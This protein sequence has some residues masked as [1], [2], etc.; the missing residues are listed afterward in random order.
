MADLRKRKKSLTFLIYIYY[1]NCSDTIEMVTFLIK[2]NFK[3]DKTFSWPPIALL[4]TLSNFDLSN[5]N[6]WS[7]SCLLPSSK[8]TS[9]SKDKQMLELKESLLTHS[10]D[11]VEM[12]RLNYWTQGM[13][14]HT[15]TPVPSTF[16]LIYTLA[17]TCTYNYRRPGR[18][19]NRQIGG[20]LPCLKTASLSNHQIQIKLNFCVTVL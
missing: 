19:K 9:P 8:R 2:L 5:L 4:L 15:Q 20:L 18:Q 12:R 17:Q 3:G 14:T 16:E 1:Q 7:P 10:S 11:P 13:D 6:T